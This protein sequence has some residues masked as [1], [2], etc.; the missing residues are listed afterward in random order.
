MAMGRAHW[1]CWQ[2][3]RRRAGRRKT[4][5]KNEHSRKMPP[6]GAEAAA[7]KAAP[8]R[9]ASPISAHKNA[10]S[11]SYIRGMLSLLVAIAIGI[12]GVTG[13]SGFVAYLVTHMTSVVIL[14]YMMTAPPSEYFPQQSLA[15]FA[16]AGI[17]DNVVLFVFMWTIAYAMVHIY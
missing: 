16:F 10:Q 12:L 4:E 9:F 2:R 15:G 13:Y 6:V 14:H 1:H 5:K 8:P 7:A 11:A 17:G 3:R